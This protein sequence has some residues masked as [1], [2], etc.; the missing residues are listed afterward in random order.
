MAKL[1]KNK[2]LLAMRYLLEEIDRLNAAPKING[3]EM[4][5]EWKEMLEI[6]RTCFEA[7]KIVANNMKEEK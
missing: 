1:T 3:C 5:E 6:D 2:L 4:T 7:C